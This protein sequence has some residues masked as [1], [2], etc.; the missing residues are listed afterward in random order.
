MS[1]SVPKG[2]LASTFAQ[3]SPPTPAPTPTAGPP[4]KVAAR[5][6][7]TLAQILTTDEQVLKRA[8]EIDSI[9]AERSQPLSIDIYRSEPGRFS[10]TWYADRS[11]HGNQYSPN[12]FETGPVWVVT[13]RG[14]LKLHLPGPR[15][16]EYDSVSYI[17]AQRTGSFLGW[18]TGPPLLTPIPSV[19]QALVTLTP[20][21]GTPDAM[22]ASSCTQ[23]ASG[24]SLR[25][26]QWPGSSSVPG[27]AGP[28]HTFY[29]EGV[30]FIP[31]EKLTVIIKGRV[32]APGTMGSTTETVLADSTFATSVGVAVPQ[33]NMPFD[34]FVIHRRGV[35]CVTVT[36][37]Q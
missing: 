16:G 14:N 29:V 35:A 11:F 24:L 36:T 23:N 7:P 9:V 32:R 19:A 3:M 28:I 13:I 31:G 26:R 5:T 25:V 2:V 1:S 34:F 37:T 33:P 20:F 27:A 17:I 6:I 12:E 30:G 18:H 15:S 22:T 10:L 21:P 8:L 4:V